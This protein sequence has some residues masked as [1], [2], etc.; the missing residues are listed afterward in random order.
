VGRDVPCA[1]SGDRAAA[2]QGGVV[3]NGEGAV[4]SGV[5]VEL[6]GIRTQLEGPAERRAGVLVLDSRRAPVGNDLN[7]HRPL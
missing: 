1:Q 4:E 7:R 5:N 2:G 6:D 3:V